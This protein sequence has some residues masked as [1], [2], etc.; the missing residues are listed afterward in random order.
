VWNSKVFALGA[1]TPAAATDPARPQARRSRIGPA[2]RHL[3]ANAPDAAESLPHRLAGAAAA[4]VHRQGRRLTAA[5]RVQQ[6][7]FSASSTLSIPRLRPLAG[8]AVGG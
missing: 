6:H 7:R 5:R 3:D 4:D 1:Q 2:K 8:H